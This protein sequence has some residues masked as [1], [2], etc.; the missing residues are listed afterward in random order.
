MLAG[1]F[2]INNPCTLCLLNHIKP[3][4]TKENVVSYIQWHSV[5]Y[6]ALLNN[7]ITCTAMGI[8]NV[9]FLYHK[10][11]LLECKYNKAISIPHYSHVCKHFT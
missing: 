4:R 1:R 3:V 9:L 10:I 2:L 7:L 6:K 5:E 8:C 11:E